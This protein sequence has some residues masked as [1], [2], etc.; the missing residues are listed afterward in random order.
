M[1]H[2]LYILLIIGLAA[3][4]SSEVTDVGNPKNPADHPSSGIESY[5]GV[6]TLVGTY[7]VQADESLTPCAIDAE[8]TPQIAAGDSP[9][10]VV[11]QHFLAFTA[12]SDLISTDYDADS[13]LFGTLDTQDDNVC[14][15]SARFVSSDVQVTIDCQGGAADASECASVFVK[16]P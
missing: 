15:A 4:C 12:A 14:T 1:R 8:E 16:L 3:G 7:Q 6:T 5:P 2:T 10:A 11:L 9:T 13:G